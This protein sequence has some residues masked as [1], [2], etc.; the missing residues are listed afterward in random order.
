MYG[1][2]Q[3]ELGVGYFKLCHALHSTASETAAIVS[4][5]RRDFARSYASLQQRSGGLP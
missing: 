5:H 2:S 1:D 4:S 3:L